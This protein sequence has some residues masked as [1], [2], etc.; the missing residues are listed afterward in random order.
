MPAEPCTAST[1]PLTRALLLALS[2][3]FAACSSGAGPAEDDP[4]TAEEA[5]LA[6]EPFLPVIR[7]L[8]ERVETHYPAAV[9]ASRAAGRFGRLPELEEAEAA[10]IFRDV[11]SLDGIVQVGV[12]IRPPQLPPLPPPERGMKAVPPIEGSRPVELWSVPEVRQLRLR[13]EVHIDREIVV[14]FGRG[15]VPARLLRLYLTRSTEDGGKILVDMAVRL[16]P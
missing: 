4:F 7:A 15:F 11:Q 5:R 6:S 9:S 3:V 2:S 13:Q 10:D 14:R 1:S 12:T 16:P 8:A